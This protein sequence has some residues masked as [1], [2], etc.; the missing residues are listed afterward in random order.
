MPEFFSWLTKTEQ[1]RFSNKIFILSKTMRKV[2]D[3]KRPPYEIKRNLFY[4]KQIQFCITSVYAVHFW[5]QL[6]R[7]HV[8]CQIWPKLY[9][10]GHQH[11]RFKI[12][13]RHCSS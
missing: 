13:L 4:L 10:Y 7:W 12:F 2:L 8:Y 5:Q 1:S 11:K 3:Q 9:L 6:Y